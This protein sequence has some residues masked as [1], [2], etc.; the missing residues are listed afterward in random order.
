MITG[1]SFF[2]PFLGYYIHLRQHRNLPSVATF[3]LLPLYSL[4]GPY[5]LQRKLFQYDASRYQWIVHFF[6]SFATLFNLITVVK[7]I[8]VDESELKS[9]ISLNSISWEVHWWFILLTVISYWVTHWIFAFKYWTLALKVQ[10][11]KQGQDPTTD[12]RFYRIVLLIGI[13]FNLVGAMMFALCF[14][15]L[16]QEQETSFLT[17]KRL[18]ISA[19]VFSSPLYASWIILVDAFRRFSKSKSSEQVISNMKVFALLFTYLFFAIGTTIVL[20][21]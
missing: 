6:Y 11:L 21:I 3:S 7:V 20:A 16:I 18:L 17:K 14:S 1:Y 5:L 4:S 9:A 12:D 8:K 15:L 10:K 13:C 2:V 19:L